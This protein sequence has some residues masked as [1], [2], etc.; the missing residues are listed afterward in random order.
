MPLLR[1]ITETTNVN[2]VKYRWWAFS[3]DGLLL[4]LSIVSIFWQSFNL[5]LD[6]TG[7]VQMEVKSAQVI[8]VGALRA[9]VDRL[10][11]GQPTITIVGGAGACD[12]PA[13]SCAMIRIQPQAIAGKDLNQSND[14]TRPAIKH[15][16]GNS[17][18]Y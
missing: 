3:V 14:A 5:G 12:T 15:E 16:L 6:F 18:T 4:V 2:F 9:Q 7:G 17:Y 10:G 11:M 1:F 8:D 13:G